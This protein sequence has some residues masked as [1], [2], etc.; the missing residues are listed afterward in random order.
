MRKNFP[1]LA[2]A[3]LLWMPA[4][5]FAGTLRIG[6][7]VVQGEQVTI[8]VLLEG[9]VADGVAALSFQLNYD[10]SMLEPRQATPG[11]A[12]QSAGKDV[13]TNVKE[14]GTY[15]V[16]MAGLNDG[17]LAMGEVTHILLERRGD[18]TST[19]I[20]ITGT[21][22]ASLQGDEIPS[23][24]S[25]GSISFAQ[26]EEDET[27]TPDAPDPSE[28]DHSPEPGAPEGGN[29]GPDTIPAPIPEN[30]PPTRRTAEVSGLTPRDTPTL[31]REVGRGVDATPAEGD[32]DAEMSKELAAA[33]TAAAEGRL[34]MASRPSET[35]DA[36]QAVNAAADPSSADEHTG[37]LQIAAASETP[38]SQPDPDANAAIP[39]QTVPEPGAISA[40]PEASP[41]AEEPQ[42]TPS[43]EPGQHE[44]AES[45]GKGVRS[46]YLFAAALAVVAIG[47]VLLRKR[48]FR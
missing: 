7:P 17:T 9:D 46:T 23:R 42:T 3:L 29:R 1:L 37:E 33:L 22:F 28:E 44:A 38:E 25:T 11:A 30:E 43:A 13:M 35:R 6:Q 20:S 34:T 4:S 5:S 10:P 27:E 32:S 36:A 31:R 39:G 14:P 45:A 47:I 18:N 8:P 41:S 19:N 26:L 40:E 21:T 16:V 2:A 24:G 12:A 48:L 15:M